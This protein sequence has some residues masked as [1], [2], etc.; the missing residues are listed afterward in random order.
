VT[1][2]SYDAIVVG[3]SLA[4]CTAAILMAREGARV[5]LVERHE[6]PESHKHLCTHFIQ[7]SALPVL[8]RLGLD[9][10]IE[11]AGGLRNSVEVHS[12]SGWIGHRLGLGSDGSPLHGYNIRRLRL[13]PMARA[14]AA[15]TPGLAMMTGR[16][17]RALI[18]RD[19]RICGVE[20]AG[21]EGQMSLI[22]RL[23]VAADGRHSEL[24]RMADVPARSSPNLRFG[25]MVTMRKVDLRRGTTSQMWF[26]GPEITYVFPN[27]DNF[28][29]IA[30]M[31]PKDRHEEYLRDPLEFVKGQVRALPD[32]PQ[33]NAAELIG[34]VLTI[35]DYPNLWRPR[36]VRGMAL[37]GD[38]MT[39]VDF[40]WGVGCGWA[41]QSGAWLCDSVSAALRIG[42]DLTP[43]LRRYDRLCSGLSPHRFL[44]NDF[45]R[46]LS[47]NPIERL[48]FA[49]AAKD[50][51]MA[52]H[53]NRFGARID[54]PVKFLS[55]AALL[56]AVWV[57]LRQSVA[58]PDGTRH[59]A[60]SA[61][62]EP[63]T[64]QIERAAQ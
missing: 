8:Q 24:A 6:R 37:V 14:L 25:A 27:D 64:P 22:A 28:T 21:H 38:A 4:G 1:T 58:L 9:R 53:F 2:D 20:L 60:A 13:D 47:M 51:N 41:F 56:K 16:S 48:M 34:P 46:R 36:V 44:I 45:S 10:L 29:V 17:A 23:V 7:P 11:E 57:N 63:V 55:P 35:K 43:A 18:E 26:N 33:L 3:A 15:R 50:A 31:C 32:A 12:P 39:S 40:L 52:R 62:A 59:S 19:G 5:A 42:D 30:A 54:G 49:A 61:P